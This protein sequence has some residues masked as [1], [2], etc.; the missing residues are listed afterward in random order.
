MQEQIN[1]SAAFQELG[2]NVGDVE[3][4]QG[5]AVAKL[6]KAKYQSK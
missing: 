2:A 6:L 3:D 5:S 1:K 4:E